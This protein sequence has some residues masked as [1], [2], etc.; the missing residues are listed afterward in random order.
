MMLEPLLSGVVALPHDDDT[1]K[2]IKK[3]WLTVQSEP[4]MAE[5]AFDPEKK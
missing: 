2:A 4:F 5:P 1:K 3:G